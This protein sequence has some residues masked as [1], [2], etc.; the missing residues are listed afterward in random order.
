MR[1]TLQHKQETRERVVRAASRHF[2]KQGGKGVTIAD[3]MRKLDLTHGGFYRHFRSKEQLLA[4][5]VAK[6]FEESATMF[7]DA[8]EKAPA[9]GELRVIVEK[10]LSLEHSANP[11]DG[12][13]LAAMG[14]EIARYP[15]TVRV[16]IDRAMREYVNKIAK[17]LPG[18]TKSERERN[19]RTLFSGMA[20]ALNLARATADAELRKSILRDA[21]EFYIK[22]FSE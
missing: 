6:G 10:Y 14:S 15:R 18:A 4:E 11:A 2:R 16:K 17:F 12:C 1:Y 9:G 22:A 13:P 3:L 8:V 5:A 20:G 21:K 7:T 19:C